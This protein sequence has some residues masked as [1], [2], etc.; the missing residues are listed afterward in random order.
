[1][2]ATRRHPLDTAWPEM[3]RPQKEMQKWLGRLGLNDLRRFARGVYPPLNAWEDENNLCVEAELPEL[4]LSHLEI[5][6]DGDEGS[7]CAALKAGVRVA[8]QVGKLVSSRGIA[9]PAEGV[10]VAFRG[11]SH[12]LAKNEEIAR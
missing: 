5:V 6:V 9:N 12:S 10:I 7:G 1:M 11:S 4:E 2:L 3:N 8:G